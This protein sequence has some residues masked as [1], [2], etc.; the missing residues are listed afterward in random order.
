MA[1]HW[2]RPFLETLLHTEFPDPQ[3]LDRFRPSPNGREV[4]A[5]GYPLAFHLGSGT[6]PGVGT[7]SLIRS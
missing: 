2:T 1:L 5:V 4:R 6:V 7:T 3:V